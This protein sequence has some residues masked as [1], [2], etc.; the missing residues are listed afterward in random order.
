MTQ[1]AAPTH[2]RRLLA[3]V[4]RL[5]T[6]VGGLLLTGALLGAW[7]LMLPAE[8]LLDHPVPVGGAVA[9]LVALAAL[10]EVAHVRVPHGDT[11]EDLAFFEAVVVVAALVLPPAFVLGGAVAGPTLVWLLKRRAP[12]KTLFNL[13]MFS[14]ATAVMLLLTHIIAGDAHESLDLRVVAALLVGTGAFGV[15]NLLAMAA[16]MSVVQGENFLGW[17]RAEAAVTLTMVA[18]NLGVAV[19]STAIATTD[20]LL[21]PFVWLPVL[22]LVHSYKQSQRHAQERE[23]GNALV[24]LSSALTAPGEPADLIAGLLPPLRKLFGADR[25][26][27]LLTAEGPVHP[28]DHVVPLDLGDGVQGRLVLGWHGE[29]DSGSDSSP[30]SHE[31]VDEPLLATTASA[32]GSVLRSGRHLAALIEESSKLQAVIDHATDG[33]AVL[34]ADG[35]VMVWSPSIRALVGEPPPP[36]ARTHHEDAVVALLA[37][38]ARDPVA[39]AATLSKSLP[40]VRAQT[41]AQVCLVGRNGD[42]RSL[43]VS[44][45]R[46]GDSTTPGLAVL[47]VHDAT[48]DRR[49]EKMKADFVATVSHELR[50]PITPIKG[51][52]RLLASRGDRM[53]PARRLHALQLIEDRADHLSRLVDDLLMASR[54]Q[55]TETSKLAIDLVTEDLRNIVRQAVTAYPLLSHRLDVRLPAHPVMVSCDTVRALQCLTNL[56]GNAEKYSAEDT[57][58]VVELRDD[59]ATGTARVIVIDRGRGIPAAEHERIFERFHRVEDPFTMRTGG[60][61]L[62]LFIARELARAMRGDITVESELDKGST[63][64]L[65]LPKVMEEM[66]LTDP[67]GARTPV[68]R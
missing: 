58:I 53:E 35:R 9:A 21:L 49:V 4:H 29:D 66:P 19:I 20:P 48:E 16:V 40:V 33:I 46:L 14:V 57:P 27:I 13:G 6:V 54:V 62:G 3:L 68:G 47:T 65:A 51:Y 5:P 28:G 59:P 30:V 34:D 38:L 22:A 63:F 52:A 2:G 12:V 39:T 25:A 17:V 61:G 31:R 15:V 67:A 32:I 8:G 24:R 45:S 10:S 42:D 36:A 64:H 41:M 50:T 23:R 18:G 1:M 43:E 56:I 7:V 60:S 11:A 26:A 37:S 44:V 55:P